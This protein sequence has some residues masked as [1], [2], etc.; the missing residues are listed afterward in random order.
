MRVVVQRVREAAV[1]IGGREVA[2]IDVG[3]LV[4]AG[5]EQDDTRE[6]VSWLAAKV[7]ALRIFPDAEGR[8]NRSVCDI[9]GHVL[10]VSQFTL[11]AATAKGNRP[12][13]TRAA[14]PGEAI[15]LY[16]AFL[17]ELEQS[18][19]RRP[20]RGVFAAEMQVSLVNDGPVTILIDSRRRE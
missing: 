9:D 17:L 12:G 20:E 19:G 2:R 1:T 4:L 10:V 7:A 5:V 14:K 16:E 11:H 3:L 8:M 6:D 13:F 15:A 18:T